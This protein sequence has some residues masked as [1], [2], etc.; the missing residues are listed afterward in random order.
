M[1]LTT[2]HRNGCESRRIDFHMGQER[3]NVNEIAGL[4]TRCEFAVRAPPHFTHARQNVCNGLLRAMMVN[5]R[6]GARLYLEYAAPH[7]RFDAELRRNRGLAL[8]A[9]RLQRALVEFTRVNNTDCRGIAHRFI[10]G[11]R[12]K[13]RDPIAS[14]A[15]ELS[16]VERN[17]LSYVGRHRSDLGCANP[18]VGMRQR[19]N[20]LRSSLFN[21]RRA[22][23][24]NDWLSVRKGSIG[25]LVRRRAAT[26]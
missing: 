18:N 15:N 10:G 11:Y 25:V 19:L 3:R 7:R 23:V 2:T 9:G 24:G 5:S 17:S 16:R 8:R 12:S 1:L 21:V 22:L 6:A 26:V 13:A 14:F 4:R 20:S